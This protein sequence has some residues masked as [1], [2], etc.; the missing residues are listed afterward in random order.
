[1][2]E[3]RE[4]VRTGETMEG[5]SRMADVKRTATTKQVAEKLGVQATTVQ[6]YSRESRIPFDRTPGGH[7]RYNLDEVRSAL[8]MDDEP[9]RLIPM[10]R[11]TGLGAGATVHRSAMATMDARRRAIVG[12]G[13]TPVVSAAGGRSRSKELWSVTIE[14]ELGWYVI[15]SGPCDIVRDPAIDPCIVVAPITTVTKQRHAQLRSGE[16]SPRE[17]PLP[18]A[19][20]ARIIAPAHPEDFWPVADLRYVTSVD[21]TALLSDTVESRRPLTGPQQKRFSLWVGRRYNRPAHSDQLEIHVLGKA[22]QL[23]SKLA[24]TFADHDKPQAASPEV[25]LVGAAREWLIGGTDRGIQLNVVVDAQSCQA[26]G[27]FDNTANAIDE[28]QIKA[29][30]KKLRQALAATLPP[31]SGYSISVKPITLDGIPAAE[32]LSLEPWLWADDREDPLAD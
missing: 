11:T 2:G 23:I 10:A 13:Q 28:G 29:A 17:F 30:T 31:D 7:R 1:M 19:D 5:V 16:Y 8:G 6:L 26:V 22:G 32:Y 15:V 4:D 21:K 25:R 18:A 3:R 14:S 12:R 9:S 24:A 20:V 27:M